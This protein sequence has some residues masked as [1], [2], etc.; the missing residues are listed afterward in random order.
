MR[1]AD[2][3]WVIN[4][5]DIKPMELPFNFAMDMAWNMDRFSFEKI[6]AYLE[7][8]AA[9][10]FGG[11]HSEAIAKILLEFSHLVGLR[12]YEAVTS[13]T[14]SVLNYR[15][16]ERILE[17]WQA[18]AAH[19][20]M[21]HDELPEEL[22]PPFYQLVHYPAAS[23]ATF[24]SVAVGIGMNYQY[25][26]ERRNH[27]NTLATQILEDFEKRYDQVEEWDAMLGGKWEKMMSQAIFDAVP[28]EPKLWASPSRDMLTNISFV[29]LRQ[30]MQFSQ[31]NL[32]IA[33]EESD[34]ALQQARWA[35]SVDSSMP[36]VEYPALLPVMDPYGPPE[37]H[38]DVFHRGDY[39]VPIDWAL[40]A[41]P[42]DWMAVLPTAG[43]LDRERSVERLRIT[44]DW[45]N[46][47][48]AFNDTVEIGITATPAEYPYFD[49]I[50]IPVL[51][52][53]VPL[54]FEGFPETA[55]FIAIESP[56]F[57]RQSTDEKD[58]VGFN[59]VPYLGTR[60]ESGS[61]ALRPYE[62]AR[63][64]AVPEA[65]WV[66]Y[67]IYLFDDRDEVMATIYITSCLETD[68]S[69]KMQYSLTLDSAQP[70][71]TRVLD[72]YVSED[73]I[74]DV[75]PVWAEQVMDQ[76]WTIRVGLGSIKAGKHTLRWAVNSPEVYLEKLVIDT[77]GG[78]KPSYLGPPQTHL[79]SL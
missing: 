21:I 42:V 30:N 26:Q 5:A 66:E 14:F 27:A 69:S 18:L 20:K 49:L 4:V 33:A 41:V 24:H 54:D 3:I 12:R 10:E 31:G 50:R 78:I 29:Q 40:D 57:Q 53:R 9:R 60:S 58:A 1:K 25:A 79:V 8:Y 22:K 17:R 77:Q 56:H 48:E 38:V 71:M 64:S 6:P 13:S 43:T 55:G 35:E 19:A 72:D 63:G 45:A 47:P 11:E 62:A 59:K 74:G 51:H 75:P 61:I 28:Q 52:R 39:R 70:N 76:V 32:G 15:E 36:T 46:V 16:A 67:D 65:A 73:H 2:R 7:H 23:G 44:I 68:P 37:R 34:S